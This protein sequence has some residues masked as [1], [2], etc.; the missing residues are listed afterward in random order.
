MKELDLEF[1]KQ[2]TPEQAIKKME[3]RAELLTKKIV[4]SDIEIS[5]SDNEK[6]TKE[7]ANLYRKIAELKGET[8]DKSLPG[9]IQE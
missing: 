8:E 3:A 1:I 6:I 2:D 4:E 9:F 7:I 5:H